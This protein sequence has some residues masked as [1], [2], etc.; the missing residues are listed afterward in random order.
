MPANGIAGKR[1]YGSGC[2]FARRLVP[3]F[4]EKPIERITPA[5]I[6]GYQHAKARAGLA[7]KTVSNHLNFLHG[8][9]KH[10]VK[11]GW[12]SGN[13]VLAVDRPRATGA[14]PDIRYLE[15]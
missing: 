9:F 13:P 3:F 2:L 4:G 7:T 12:T 1:S 14:D 10:T 11:R 8:V 5:D 6:E 15:P